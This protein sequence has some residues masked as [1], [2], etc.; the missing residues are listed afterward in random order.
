M[1]NGC[2]VGQMMTKV[3]VKSIGLIIFIGVALG[4][5]NACAINDT[6]QQHEKGDEMNGQV[7]SNV[8]QSTNSQI[9]VFKELSSPQ[10][11]PNGWRLIWADEF[12]DVAATLDKWTM[13]DMA[14]EQNNE[15]Q[16]Y[17]PNNVKIED[18]YLTLI[19]KD[20][21]IHGRNFTSGAIHTKNTMNFL[22][23]KVEMR[24]KLPIGQGIFPAFW[25]MTNKEDTWLP[26]I[27]ILEMIGNRPDE[28]WMVLHGLD[29]NN[30]KNTV[31]DYY[32]GENYTSE[33]HTFGVEWTPTNITWRI[34]GK[35]RFE[36]NEYIPKEKMFLYMNIAIGGD[37]P[38]SPDHTTQF[39]ALFEIDYVRFYQKAG[40]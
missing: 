6:N 33:F 32:I 14:V 39:P 11:A 3:Y 10:K 31:S 20:E 29:E 26:E 17:S 18:G 21:N 5:L 15:L 1:E 12:D 37:W 13:E 16:Y 36:T 34:D 7:N 22:Y 40:V 25:M 9:K 38:G 23:G 2:D 35:I 8:I 28:I 24:A 4:I 30:K 27:D 19:A